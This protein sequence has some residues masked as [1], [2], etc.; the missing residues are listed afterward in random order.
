MCGRARVTSSHEVSLPPLGDAA[1][2]VVCSH[3][4]ARRHGARYGRHRSVS[5]VSAGVCARCGGGHRRLQAGR[6]RPFVAAGRRCPAW[7]AVHVD[8]PVPTLDGHADLAKLAVAIEHDLAPQRGALTSRAI[9]ALVAAGSADACVKQMVLADA[10]WHRL[11]RGAS[12]C[13]RIRNYAAR[14]S[15][16][17]GGN[18]NHFSDRS[19]PSGPA[20]AC[21]YAKEV[22]GSPSRSSLL[23]ARVGARSGRR[24]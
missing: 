13:L 5:G 2:A 19:L 24:I 15:S 12:N 22:G 4:S 9:G 16:A 11:R 10:W 6:G 14:A 21:R 20:R 23:R 7:G 8:H 18:R 17:L 1:S 3:C